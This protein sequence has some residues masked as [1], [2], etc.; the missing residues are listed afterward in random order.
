MS[1]AANTL[2]EATSPSRCTL[3]RRLG[4]DKRERYY[5]DAV[6]AVCMGAC[7]DDKQ[8]DDVLRDLI[9]QPVKVTNV[10]IVN[11]SGQLDLNS[12]D[13]AL[14]TF[15]DQIDLVVAVASA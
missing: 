11:A 13:L 4:A 8:V 15:D 7:R 6:A 12:D 5:C 10:G 2:R 14:G 9:G 1:P 3:L